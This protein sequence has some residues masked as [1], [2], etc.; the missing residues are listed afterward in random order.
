VYTDE[1]SSLKP[2]ANNRLLSILAPLILS[3]FSFLSLHSSLRFR[4]LMD[5][6]ITRISLPITSEAI[7]LRLEQI[8]L[9]PMLAGGLMGNN[10]FLAVNFLGGEVYPSQIQDDL[11]RLRQKT[12]A[13]T[14]FLVIAAA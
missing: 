4:D 3:G 6:Q 8:L 9:K 2:H 12:G 11:A 7:E 10:H 1:P 5:R 13:I 14:T